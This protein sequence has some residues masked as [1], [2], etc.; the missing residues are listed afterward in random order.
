MQW[1]EIPFDPPQRTLRQFAGTGFAAG[2]GFAAWY[3]FV[4][5]NV[6]AAVA[7]AGASTAL[8][9]IGW[10]RPGLLRPVFVGWMV[11]AFP[12]GWAVSFAL[13]AALYYGLFTPVGLLFRLA[14]RDRLALRR[15]AERASY[16]EPKP[17]VTDLRR[18]HQQF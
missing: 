11:V 8:G 3:G 10:V 6:P 14:G 15:P 12:I 7:L 9:L 5:G 1:A 18:Y 2:A 13:L 16:W 4:H 17:D